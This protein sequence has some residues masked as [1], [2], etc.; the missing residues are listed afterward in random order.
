MTMLHAS[1]AGD[2]CHYCGHPVA[3]SSLNFAHRR[4]TEQVSCAL[5]LCSVC[6]DRVEYH[7]H[8]ALSGRIF[9]ES[10]IPA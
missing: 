5:R 4:R 9:A 2:S 3:R 8:I 6:A 1:N 10:R 7:L